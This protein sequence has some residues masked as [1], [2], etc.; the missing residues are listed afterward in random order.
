MS[1]KARKASGAIALAAA[2]VAWSATA[3]LRVPGRRHPVVQAGL[4]ATLVALTRAPLGLRPPAL[5]SGIRAGLPPAAVAAAGMAASTALPQVRDAM[6]RRDPPRPAT[7]WLALRIPLGTVWSE[8]AAYRAALGTVAASAFGAQRGRILQ[9]TAFG[10]SHIYD[11]RA[12]GEPIGPTVL[13]TAVAGWLFGWLAERSGSL[14]AP[15]LAHLAIN[16]TAAL[17]AVTIHRPIQRRNR[18]S[19]RRF[20]GQPPADAARCRC[21]RC[22]N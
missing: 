18:P 19:S 3:G 22:R 1:P 21:R 2:L 10:L 6:A 15:M 11:A 8:E 9:A 16:E 12:A 4:A 20:A 5:W 14:A 17:A 7:S 13:A